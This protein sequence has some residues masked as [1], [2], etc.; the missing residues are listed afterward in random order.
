[1]EARK[2]GQKYSTGPGGGIVFMKPFEEQAALFR[3]ER[4]SIGPECLKVFGCSLMRCHGPGA[5]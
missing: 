3:F 1:M 5:Q 2:L 4:V